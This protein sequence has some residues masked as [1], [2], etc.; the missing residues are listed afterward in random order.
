MS[1]PFSDHCQ[2]LIGNAGELQELLSAAEDD[3][4]QHGCKYVEIRPL[5]SEESCMATATHFARSNRIADHLLDLARSEAEI[6]QGF[7]KNCIRRKIARTEREK[8]HYEE[9]RSEELLA[10]FY[11]L[12]LLTRRRHQ[13]PPQPLAWFRNLM[14]CLGDRLLIRV[15]YADDR[16]IASIIT[17]SFKNKLIDK[18]NCSDP[19]FNPLGGTVLLIWRAIQDALSRGMTEFDLGRTDLDNPGLITF[20]DHWGARR[21]EVNYYR[22]PKPA[23]RLFIDSPVA[24]AAERLLVSVPDSM[25]SVVGGLLYRHVG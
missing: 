20:K 10:R 14:D 12:N 19:A 18:Y 13:V 1:L 16:P 25:F 24:A 7:H 22:C 8:L 4:R 11:R 17:L 21:T 23:G 3:A 5:V 6:V 15:A 2:P 9:G